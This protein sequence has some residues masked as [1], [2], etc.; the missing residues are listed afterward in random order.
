MASEISDESE[1]IRL[2]ILRLAREIPEGRVVS[3]GVLG[4]RS[5]PP[6]SGYICGRIMALVL[7]DVPWWRVVGKD[8]NLPIGK[9]GPEMAARQR[10]LLKSEGIQFDENGAISRQFFED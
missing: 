2:Q 6:I 7:E 9:R 5:D 3:Y 4:K 8:G 10:E 1:R